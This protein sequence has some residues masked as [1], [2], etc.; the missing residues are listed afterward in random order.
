[1]SPIWSG[2]NI[3]PIEVTL[4]EIQDRISRLGYRSSSFQDPAS[5]SKERKKIQLRLGISAILT[6]HVMMISLALYAGF[7]KDL[8]P[9]GIGYLSYPLWILSYAGPLLWGTSHF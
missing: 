8:G 3:F 5:D 4:T 2:L 9:E 7:F 1:M 6:V